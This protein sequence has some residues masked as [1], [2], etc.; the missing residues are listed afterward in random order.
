M[1]QSLKDKAIELSS[2]GENG[3]RKVV[4][5]LSPMESAQGDIEHLYLLGYCHFNL[6]NWAA[7]KN[8]LSAAF[9]INN[10]EPDICYMLGLAIAN[11]EDGGHKSWGIRRDFCK[12]ALERAIVIYS[13]NLSD[14]FY[15]Q[16]CLEMLA[17]AATY[18][19]PDEDAEYAYR[20]LVAMHP[21]N[22]D[23][24]QALAKIT[25]EVD[26]HESLSLLDR[27]PESL[28][29]Q[30]INEDKELL[31]SVI[32]TQDE[33]KKKKKSAVSRS[34]YP[35]TREMSG[36][37][38]EV[39]ARTLVAELPKEQ[40]IAQDKGIFCIGSCF[41]REIATQLSQRN[42]KAMFV[43]MA[44]HINST[45]ANRHLLDWA[46]GRCEGQPKDRISQLCA[47]MNI[48]PESI[49]KSIRDSNIVIYTLG[50]APVFVDKQ[51]NNQFVMPTKSTLSSSVLAELY[52]FRT[53]TVAENV[54]N[55]KYIFA[56]LKEINPDIKLVITVSPVP[57]RTTFEFKSAVMA[58]SLSKSTLRVA[59]HEFVSS[60]SDVLYWPSFEIVRWIGGH[61]GP[62]FGGDDGASLHVND[63]VVK[64]ITDSFIEHY[65]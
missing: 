54:E 4:E 38:R 58:D 31:Y 30:S 56:R 6:G 50:V 35:T 52:D 11:C 46:L 63:E 59:A 27:I 65:S 19:G 16:S 64:A 57:L 53:T 9:E 22:P 49:V 44:E 34:K 14:W 13:A 51:N 1:D 42:L 39:I 20:S 41:A 3:L 24:L 61:V 15:A 5:L 23:Y 33:K 43:E 40:L 10:N 26:I 32:N 18:V 29:N 25:A 62:Y 28:S 36:N 47:D 60:H 8:C 7:A 55:L 37:L 45:Y 21:K 48:T 12:A 2:D 17:T